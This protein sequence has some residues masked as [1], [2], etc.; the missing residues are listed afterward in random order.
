METVP[1]TDDVGQWTALYRKMTQGLKGNINDIL[2]DT[3]ASVEGFP[4]NVTDLDG[5][6]E[7]PKFAGNVL[8]PPD[9]TPPVP[10]L[11]A[12]AQPIGTYLGVNKFGQVVY[13]QPSQPKKKAKKKKK[14]ATPDPKP[15]KKNS[16]KTTKKQEKPKKR[17]RA[18]ITK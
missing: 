4:A 1:V 18:K 13:Q 11:F 10:S 9:P 12:G 7:A 6:L 2:L 16:S 17:E 5:Q 8:P 14:T 15:S 3:A